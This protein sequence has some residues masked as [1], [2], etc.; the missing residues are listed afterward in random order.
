MR[1]RT[2]NAKRNAIMGVLNNVL[3]ILLPFAVRTALLYI[4]GAEYLGLSGLFTSLL[5]V[6]NMAELGISSAI[7]YKMY[8][9]MS[10]GDWQKIRALLAL[11]RRY[12][13]IIG[14]FILV[15]GIMLIPWLPHIISGSYP[16]NINLYVLYAIYLANTVI[17]YFA[18]AYRSIIL[19]VAQREDIILNIGTVLSISKNIFMIL[20]LLLCQNYYAYVIWLPIYTIS[21]NIAIAYV[22]KRR[23]PFLYCAGKLPISDVRDIV[24]QIKGLAI[25]KVSGATST[26]FDNI[27]LSLYC[28]LRDV[29]IYSNYYYVMTALGGFLSVLNRAVTAG[30]GNSLVTES[31]EK[32]YSDFKRLNFYFSWIV[33]WFTV[34]LYCLYQPFMKLW[35]GVDLTASTQTMTLFCLFFYVSNVGQARAVYTTA[36]GIWW[37]FRKYAIAQMTLNLVLNFVLGYFWGIDGIVLTTIFVTTCCAIIG[38]GKI[39]MYLCFKRDASEYFKL[40]F[41]YTIVTALACFVSKSLCE[42]FFVQS[43]SVEILLNCIVCLFIPNIIFATCAGIFQSHKEYLISIV[44]IIKMRL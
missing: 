33:G 42:T 7:A 26:S 18:F 14:A 30:V 44:E 39:T 35:A 43:Y 36:A 10:D 13:R 38:I 12:Y 22:T 19:S 27:V 40:L 16:Q 1:S 8:R 31:I 15:L 2:Y 34:C 37:E 5:Q 32:N 3:N 6:L 41:F 20:A 17:S 29:A 9:P 21:Y 28:G 24:K 4:L 11:Y 23:F 25:G